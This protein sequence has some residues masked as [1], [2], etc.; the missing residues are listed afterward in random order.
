VKVALRKRPIPFMW[1]WKHRG[2]ICGGDEMTRLGSASNT[3]AEIENKRKLYLRKGAE[4]FWYCD[5]QGQMTFFN[6]QGL[7]SKSA[8][9]PVFPASVAAE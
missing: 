1:W 8:L 4:E 5:A 7:L 6:Q 2:E 9:G 3:P